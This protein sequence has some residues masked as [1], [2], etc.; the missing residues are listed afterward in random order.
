MK[1]IMKKI[2][3]FKP[4]KNCTNI[5]GV[6]IQAMECL[7][8]NAAS[9]KISQKQVVKSASSM[10]LVWLGVY[11]AVVVPLWCMKGKGTNN[12]FAILMSLAELIFFILNFRLVLLLFS[13]LLLLP[14]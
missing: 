13:M 1:E 9:K 4:P 7:L 6:G 12:Y 14:A 10:F 8:Q 2:V 5:T 3:D 11:L